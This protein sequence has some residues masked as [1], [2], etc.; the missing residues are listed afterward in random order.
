MGT[1]PPLVESTQLPKQ[2]KMSK[3]LCYILER[4]AAP[5]AIP[6]PRCLLLPVNSLELLIVE[7]SGTDA[8][9]NLPGWD[10]AKS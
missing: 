8:S 2:H 9:A 7:I 1:L 3:G 10:R 5:A 6:H 4:K